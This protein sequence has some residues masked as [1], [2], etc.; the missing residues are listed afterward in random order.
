MIILGVSYYKSRLAFQRAPHLYASDA[1]KIT[2]LISQLKDD[3]F[4]RAQS[5]MSTHNIDSLSFDWF[6]EEFTKVFDHPLQ[7]SEA[8]K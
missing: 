6:R 5:F 1:S 7:Q 4:C 8:I 3:A 2:Y